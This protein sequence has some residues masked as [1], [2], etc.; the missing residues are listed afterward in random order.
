M[1][2]VGMIDL[3]FLLSAVIVDDLVDVC[4]TEV[5][6]GISILLLAA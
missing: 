3:Q 2:A 4:G 5:L 1:D 6:A